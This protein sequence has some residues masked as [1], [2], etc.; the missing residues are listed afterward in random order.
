LWEEYLHRNDE[1]YWVENY[2][3]ETMSV[4]DLLIFDN[5]P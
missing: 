4:E 3:G 5:Q 2:K 1:G